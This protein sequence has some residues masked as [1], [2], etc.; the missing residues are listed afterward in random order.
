MDK[1][2]EPANKTVSCSSVK[3]KNVF[4]PLHLYGI[5]KYAI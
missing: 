3:L 4:V 5:E 2:L 1:C